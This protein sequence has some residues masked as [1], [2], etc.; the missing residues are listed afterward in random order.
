M[1]SI[2]FLL[3]SSAALAGC[4]TAPQPTRGTSTY[5]AA[6]QA[7]SSTKSA[8]QDVAKV[9]KTA[10][11]ETQASF[12]SSTTSARARAEILLMPKIQTGTIMP[13][14]ATA[15]APASLDAEPHPLLQDQWNPSITRTWHVRLENGV[16]YAIDQP[17]PR[18]QVGDQVTVV[19]YGPRLAI[20]F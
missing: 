4:A 2:L 10:W 5:S 8:S 18:T 14:S 9:A 11:G 20:A 6:E 13:S 12:V 15:V 3:L 17:G 7:I 16:T 19:R 1:R